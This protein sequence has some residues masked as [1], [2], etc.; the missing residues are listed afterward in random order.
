[1]QLSINPPL[2]NRQAFH[3][4]DTLDFELV[5]IGRAIEALPYFVYTFVEIGRRGLGKERA[6]YDISR[7]DLLRGE[8]IIQIYDGETQT[9]SAYPSK[10]K[11]GSRPEKVAINGITLHF[12]TPL[13]LKVKGHLLTQLTFFILFERLAQRIELLAAFYG[14][15]GPLPDLTDLKE[16][17]NEIR[18]TSDKLHWYDWERYSASQKSLIKLGGLKG[19][20]R[21]EGDLGPFIPYLRLGEH[22]NVGQG[23]SFGLGR[24]DVIE[25]ILNE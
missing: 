13:R 3:P 23:T 18:V 8:N 6:K 12:L 21:F 7:I 5:L 17:S 19:K 22:V 25:V 24:Y 11:K 9:I 16:Q 4:N 14:N 1:M 20:I 15:N 10:S 2:T